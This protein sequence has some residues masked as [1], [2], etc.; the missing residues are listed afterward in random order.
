MSSLFQFSLT[1]ET[2]IG[3]SFLGD[4]LPY[5]VEIGCRIAIATKAPPRLVPAL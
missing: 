2:T 1:S 3:S 5:T 4:T